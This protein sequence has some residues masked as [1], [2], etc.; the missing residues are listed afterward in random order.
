[1]ICAPV[2]CRLSVVRLIGSSLFLLSVSMGPERGKI[3]LHSFNCQYHFVRKTG[4]IINF[5]TK[6]LYLKLTGKK[7]TRNQNDF[8]PQCPASESVFIMS[9]FTSTVGLREIVSILNAKKL[10]FFQIWQNF[11]GLILR[12]KTYFAV[13]NVSVLTPNHLSA[14]AGSSYLPPEVIGHLLY[15]TWIWRKKKSRDLKNEAVENCPE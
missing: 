1:M 14:V 5:C 15:P 6:Q 8:S 9:E 12:E 2:Y 11:Y 3:F 10:Y 13:L 4:K 7:C